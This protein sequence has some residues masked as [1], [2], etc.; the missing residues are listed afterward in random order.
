M[1]FIY[2]LANLITE[3]KSIPRAKALF[4]IQKS[5]MAQTLSLSADYIDKTIHLVRE[6]SITRLMLR[7]RDELKESIR[8]VK[9]VQ[10]SG[11][12]Q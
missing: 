9:R 1:L 5:K 2:T 6:E 8:T 10:F 11:S 3:E 12:E 7:S 4:D